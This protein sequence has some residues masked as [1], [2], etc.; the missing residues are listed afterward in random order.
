LGGGVSA[1]SESH[2]KE[3]AKRGEGRGWRRPTGQSSSCWPRGR[4]SG[5]ERVGLFFFIAKWDR[6]SQRIGAS[7]VCA[8]R[9]VKGVEEGAGAPS[10]QVFLPWR[11]R[12]RLGGRGTQREWRLSQGVVLGDV[13]RR[14][15]GSEGVIVFLCDCLA[16][17]ARARRVARVE[18]VPDVSGL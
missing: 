2:A 13:G 8:R 15:G 16:A 17:Q 3:N 18:V 10:C 14:I 9:H 4:R 1:R 12:D 5:A 11:L 7:A 6:S